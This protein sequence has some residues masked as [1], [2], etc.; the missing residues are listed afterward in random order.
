MK[1]NRILALFLTACFLCYGAQ[2]EIK[3]L[4]VNG[5]FSENEKGIAKGWELKKGA[6]IVSENGNNFL[7]CE[8]QNAGAVQSIKIDP[9]WKKL[10][11]S[12]RMRSTDIV[13]GKH[14]WQDGRVALEFRGPDNKHIGRWTKMAQ[15]VGSSD[16]TEYSFDLAVNAGATTLRVSPCMLGVSGML[17]VDDIVISVVE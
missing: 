12:C 3:N 15:V 11:F 17:D 2:G 4:I 7:R 1:V 9:K 6:L 16:W 10:K 14:S 13:K 5:S 8:N